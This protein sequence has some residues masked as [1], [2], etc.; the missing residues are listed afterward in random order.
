VI[1]YWL[2]SWY[3]RFGGTRCPLPPSQW[4]I[5]W[6]TDRPTVWLAGWLAG[7][8]TYSPTHSF[9]FAHSLNHS[10]IHSIT[11]SLTHPFTRT[12][13]QSL[14]RSPTHAITR[15]LNRSITLTYS[16][17]CLT[18]R[19]NFTYQ[20]HFHLQGL[21][22]RSHNIHISSHLFHLES[23]RIVCRSICLTTLCEVP[24]HYSCR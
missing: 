1:L 13:T 8:L 17:V 23:S 15:S 4:L 24:K 14:T 12:L 9:A 11:H 5:L 21:N 10:P 18:R 22:L 16:L 20:L 19:T 3:R 6:Q 2:A 7:W